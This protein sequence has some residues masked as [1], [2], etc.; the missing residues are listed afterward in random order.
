MS[1]TYGALIRRAA[2]EVAC[3]AGAETAG[4]KPADAAAA[5]ELAAYRETLRSMD[6]H[7]R[8]LLHPHAQPTG[9]TPPHPVGFDSLVSAL[10]D[11]LHKLAGPAEART[12]VR[13]SSHWHAA[14]VAIGAA[15]DLLATHASLGGGARTPEADEVLTSVPARRAAIVNLADVASAALSVPVTLCSDG[16]GPGHRGPDPVVAQV[17]AQ[18]CSRRDRAPATDPLDGLGLG[19][20]PI[21]T[22]HPLLELGDRLFRLRLLAWAGTREIWP[23]IDDLKVFAVLGQAVAVHASA[24]LGC[25]A[26]LDAWREASGILRPWRSSVPA[27]V[28]VVAHSRRVIDLLAEVAPCDPG[29]PAHLS[30]REVGQALR[31]ATRIARAIAAWNSDTLSRLRDTRPITRAR[32]L[33]GDFVTDDPGLVAAK[34]ADRSVEMPDAVYDEL[35]DAY[36][37]AS[38]AASPPLAHGAELR[39]LGGHAVVSSRP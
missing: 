1:V 13:Q 37:V 28:G 20:P 6:L 35:R 17:L 14:A 8:Q 30:D 39:K 11:Q 19:R 23:A 33:S 7:F 2:G 9:R 22:S 4:S 26:G 29:R 3:A 12:A 34:L 25:D 5:R 10:C 15:G 31:G 32:N 21:D 16:M 38:S 27:H 36:L 18:E 24:V